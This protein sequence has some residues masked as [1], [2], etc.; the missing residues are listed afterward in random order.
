MTVCVSFAENCG[1]LLSL[2]VCGPFYK[3]LTT[4]IPSPNKRT[5]VSA[6]LYIYYII[7]KSLITHQHKS[8]ILFSVYIPSFVLRL[9]CFVVIIYYKGK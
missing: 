1:D 3:V 2:Y 8:Y 5:V 6:I 4:V 9:A 7:I